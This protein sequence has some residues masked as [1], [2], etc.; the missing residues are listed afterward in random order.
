MPD[1]DVSGYL[2]STM[3][4]PTA[5]RW[6]CLSCRTTIASSTSEAPRCGCAAPAIASLEEEPE[7]TT[8]AYPISDPFGDGED[9]VFWLVTTFGGRMG[10][11]RTERSAIAVWY[12][13]IQPL[14]PLREG[15]SMC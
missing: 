5:M 15:A 9:R 3:I 14:V 4:V 1:D 2:P 11:H 13:T 8:R 12:P 6:M 10:V 7:P